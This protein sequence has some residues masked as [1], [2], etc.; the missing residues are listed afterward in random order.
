MPFGRYYLSDCIQAADSD[1]KVEPGSLVYVNG[2]SNHVCLALVLA[3]EIDFCDWS[4]VPVATLMSDFIF[5][6]KRLLG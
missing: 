5:E 3:I 4:R 1:A 2:K 6:D